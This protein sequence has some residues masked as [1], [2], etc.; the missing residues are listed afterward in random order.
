MATL[1]EVQDDFAHFVADVKAKVA[2]LQ[3]KID[4]GGA[5]EAADLDT[6]KAAIDAADAELNPPPA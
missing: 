5:V 2:E 4:A 6:L 1:Q 3:A